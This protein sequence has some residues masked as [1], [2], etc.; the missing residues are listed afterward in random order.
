MADENTEFFLDLARKAQEDVSIWNDYIEAHPDVLIDFSEVD[1]RIEKNKSIS[2]EHFIFPEGNDSYLLSEKNGVSFDKAVINSLTSFVGA[3][4]GKGTS[5]N[6]TEFQALVNFSDATFGNNTSFRNAT[7]EYS[8]YFIRCV[9]KGH[10]VFEGTSLGFDTSFDYSEFLGPA[11]FDGRDYNRPIEPKNSPVSIDFTSFRK[12]VFAKEVSFSNRNIS[13]SLDFSDALFFA[14]PKFKRTINT[15]NINLW[16]VTF[17]FSDFFNSKSTIIDPPNYSD[18][19]RLRKI[20]S[21]IHEHDTERD[22]FI[23][24]K[25]IESSLLWEKWKQKKSLKEWWKAIG[26][27]SWLAAY[28]ISSDCGRSIFRPVASWVVL[29]LLCWLGFASFF[30]FKYLDYVTTLVWGQSIPVVGALKTSYK[31]AYDTLFGDSVPEL[32]LIALGTLQE[33]LS[34]VLIFLLLLALRNKFK[35]G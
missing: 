12:C 15:E 3:R 6:E 10:V 30:S 26:A 32:G 17:N 23:I 1:F 16:N 19:R 21:D 18:I 20:A 9:F 7:F 28:S 11:M 8:P 31:K 25:Q 27:R 14:P 2:F 5:F 29:N 24:E 4:F 22:L 33:I 13:E 35:I 34:G